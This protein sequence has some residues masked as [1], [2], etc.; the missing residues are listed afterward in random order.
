MKDKEQAREVI[1][2]GTVDD[3]TL[4]YYGACD[5]YR[6]FGDLVNVMVPVTVICSTQTTAPTPCAANRTPALL[7]LAALSMCYRCKKVNGGEW[8]L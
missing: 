1:L 3:I 5:I 8:V 6:E 2:K 7:R 4:H